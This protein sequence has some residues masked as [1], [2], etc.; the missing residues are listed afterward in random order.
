M[1]NW[2]G[3]TKLS[4][5]RG[6][7]GASKFK[8]F[9]ILAE[10]PPKHYLSVRKLCLMSGIGYYSLARALP[11]WTRWEYV[12]RYPTTFIGQGD[13]MY[14]LLAKG[15]SWLALALMQ[16]PNANIFKHEL[17]RWQIHI[18]PEW[19][20]YMALPF[21]DFVKRLHDKILELGFTKIR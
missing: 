3:I 2:D 21:E 13:Y 15:K 17:E 7:Y 6:R 5:K 11:R 16:L 12:A 19:N 14:R 4:T 1:K 9:S 18:A 10:L 8:A 20:E